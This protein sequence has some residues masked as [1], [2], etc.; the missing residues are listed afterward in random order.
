MHLN[1]YGEK[2]LWI[3]NLLSAIR[4]KTIQKSAVKWMSLIEL[5]EICSA[6]YKNQNLILYI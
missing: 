1:D 6:H 2:K 3:F 5:S 4:H